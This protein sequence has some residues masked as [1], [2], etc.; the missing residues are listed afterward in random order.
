[1][2]VTPL[3]AYAQALKKPTFTVHIEPALFVSGSTVYGEIE[4]DVNRLQQDDT[5]HIY[6]ELQGTILTKNR[7]AAGSDH[8]K[9]IEN[10]FLRE[11]ITLWVRERDAHTTFRGVINIPFELKLSEDVPPSFGFESYMNNAH[12]RY[13]VEVVGVGSAPSAV[14]TRVKFPVV[15]VPNDPISNGT[16]TQLKLGW[17]HA[18]GRLKAE[19]KVRKYPWGEY[20]HVRVELLIPHVDTFPL[21]TNIPYTIVITTLSAPTKRKGNAGPH[22]N[23]F[24]QVPRSASEIDFEMRRFVEMETPYQPSNPEEHVVDIISKAHAPIPPVT[25]EIGKHTWIPEE[26]HDDRGRWRQEAT[27]SSNMNLRYTPTFV[28]EEVKIKYSLFLRV[29]FS[30]SANTIRLCMPIT[31]GSGIES[32]IS[33]GSSIQGTIDLPS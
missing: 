24:P 29:E 13:A 4:L 25:V 1:M 30:G 5:G 8:F 19:D 17:S 22:K 15:V 14:N 20:A 16:R 11:T 7:M 6:A 18:W 2:S 10:K 27:F 26:G 12:V 28:T 9:L 21:F 32:S 33:L 3:S 23:L 31:I